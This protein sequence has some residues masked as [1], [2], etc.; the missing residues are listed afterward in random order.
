MAIPTMAAPTATTSASTPPQEEKQE[1]VKEK[2]EFTIRLEKIDIAL[3]AKV[4]REIKNLIPGCNLVEAKKF[5]ESVPKVIKE[6]VP[7][8]EAEKIKATLEGFGATVILE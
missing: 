2:T 1:V 4:I 5:V 3:K 8:E 6:S 7:K